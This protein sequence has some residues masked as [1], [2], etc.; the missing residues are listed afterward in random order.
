M[1]IASVAE[2]KSQFSAFLKASAAGPI[3]VTRNGRPVAVILGVQDED[4]IE[5]LLM[6]YSPRL[7]AIL[8]AS[9]KQIRE[10]DVLSHEAFW[11]QVEGSRASKRRGKRKA[12][13]KSR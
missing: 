11:D 2:I 5:R 10:D 6:A 3:V 4:E 9:R 7:Q 12:G 1:K 13:L 8:E